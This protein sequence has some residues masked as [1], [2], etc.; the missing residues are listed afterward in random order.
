MPGVAQRVGRG[1]ARHWFCRNMYEYNFHIRTVQRLDII[2]FFY[3]PTD[4]QLNC[5]KTILKFTLKLT[6]KQLLQV[7]VQSPSSGSLIAISA[8]HIH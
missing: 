8:T 6:L 4:V 5:L 3:P 1:T 7:S 2:N